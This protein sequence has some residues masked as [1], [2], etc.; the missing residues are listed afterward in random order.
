MT[1]IAEPQRKTPLRDK[2]P[3]DKL[4]EPEMRQLRIHVARH[5]GRP[6][7]WLAQLCHVTEELIEQCRADSPA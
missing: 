4:T 7:S 3:R 2:P 6:A 5:P 1:D